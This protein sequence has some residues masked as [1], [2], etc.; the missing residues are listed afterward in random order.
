MVDAVANRAV[1]LVRATG[2]KAR[3]WAHQKTRLDAEERAP[4]ILQAQASITTA[5]SQTPSN[6]KVNRHSQTAYA[7]E[8]GVRRH[9]G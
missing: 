8:R 2:L 4:P 5:A 3:Q 9:A 1:T 6:P 7:G